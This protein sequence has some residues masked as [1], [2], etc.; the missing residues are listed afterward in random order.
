MAMKLPEGFRC[1]GT[2]CGIKSEGP[3]LGVIVCEHPG[4]WAGV[5]T[6]NAA[7]AAPVKWC[8]G[9][10]GNSVSALVVNSGNANACTGPQGELAVHQTAASVAQSLG[11]S[12]E[13]V[14]VASTGP[15]GVP[16]P[17]D[18]ISKAIPSAIADVGNEATDFARSILTTDSVIKVVEARAGDGRVVGIA[19][20]AAMVAPNMA[21]MLAFILTDANPE[22]CDVQQ[23]LSSAVNRSF[24]R[25]SVDACEST[26]DS[27]FLLT[28]RRR[29]SSAEAF[30]EAVTQVCQ[31]LAEMIVRDAEGASRFVR[32][33][34][35]GAP[36]DES[37]TRLGR[38]AAASDLWR[39]AAG[40]GDPNWGRIL[41]A[42]GASDR[43]LD[44]AKMSI[45]IGD[46]T[47]FASGVPCGDRSR[48][49][50]AMA[51]PEFTVRCVVG[52]GPG[53]S[54]VLTCDLTP[55]YVKLNAQGTT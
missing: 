16:L 10:R 20:G 51:E 33:E 9:N 6:R 14:L 49:V 27:V 48:A 25:I 21:T 28:S 43:G 23:V 17:V 32:I 46:E 3:D 45:A 22:G 24:N 47:L 38:A 4:E 5:F 19:K 7:A 34:I 54:E 52:D 53:S 44:L 26:N 40:G 8:K 50:T 2:S 36:D 29:P 18:L 31:D 37:A 42:L 12:P 1:S 41:S 55:D 11:C 30:E 13:D 39:A 15:I 35:S